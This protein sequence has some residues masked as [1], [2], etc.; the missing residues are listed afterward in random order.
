MAINY[1]LNLPAVTG[2]KKIEFSYL[3][4]VGITRSPFTFQQQVQKFPGQLWGVEIELPKMTSAQ[5][6]EWEAFILK[7]NGQQGT[8][9]VGD[10]LREE[11]RGSALGSPIVNGIA[12][13]GNSLDTTGWTPNEFELLLPGDLIQLPNNRLHQ[14]LNTVDS[15]GSGDA[16][17]DIWPSLRESPTDGSTIITVNPQGIFR[18][19]DNAD[20]L[21]AVNTNRTMTTKFSATEAL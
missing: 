21:R 4:S 2:F 10:P 1:P 19:N 3:T 9:L 14:V 15:D 20:T 6:A 11:P 8:F 18:L 16:T 12:Q 5:S 17:I 13:L 7:L